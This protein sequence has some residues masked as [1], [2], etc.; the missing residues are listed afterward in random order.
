M[1]EGTA[2]P[3]DA[4]RVVRFGDDAVLV[5]LADLAAVR[6]L[7]GAIRAL[8]DESREGAFASIVDQVPAART[9][10]LRVDHQVDL[11]ELA[12][13]VSQ[14][15]ALR[16]TT[17]AQA[18]GD[19]VVLEVTYDGEDLEAVAEL[20]G[21]TVA[22]VVARHAAGSYTVAFG[23]F[24]PGFAYLSGLDA[25]LRVPRLS[26]PRQKVPAGSV[27]VAD[28]YTAVYPA[29]TPGGWRL[30]GSCDVQLFDVDRDPPSLLRPGTHVRFVERR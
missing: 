12:T 15:W 16:D 3:A 6:A 30:L 13:A 14:A 29:A 11:G 4:P 2:T 18:Q 28:E 9:L 21:L 25:A 10:L 22:E 27:A 17:A 23:G 7:D 26:S 20:T 5:E 1:T 8:R 24:M 19:M